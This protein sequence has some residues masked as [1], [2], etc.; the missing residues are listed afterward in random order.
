M[1]LYPDKVRLQDLT[2]PAHPIN[3]TVDQERLLVT[4]MNKNPSVKAAM[5]A[6]ALT[7]PVTTL[8]G[9][10]PGLDYSIRELIE[11][12][13]EGAGKTHLLNLYDTVLWEEAM[14][15]QLNPGFW[16]MKTLGLWEVTPVWRTEMGEITDWVTYVDLNY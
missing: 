2:N 4:V 10:T 8:E 9:Y 7:A 16:K 15:E 13:G 12:L 3:T 11:M 6:Y 1:K 5:A 14:Y